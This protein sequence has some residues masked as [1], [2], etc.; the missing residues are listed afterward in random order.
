MLLCHHCRDV[1][2]PDE[3]ALWSSGHV[4]LEYVSLSVYSCYCSVVILEAHLL[5]HPVL[6]AWE[7]TRAGSRL[8]DAIC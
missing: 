7:N 8:K 5:H 1:D 6:P 4:A 2:C 3:V